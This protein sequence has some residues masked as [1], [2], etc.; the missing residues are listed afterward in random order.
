M[1]H[2]RLQFGDAV[3]PVAIF[4]GKIQVSNGK[5]CHSC[6]SGSAPCDPPSCLHIAIYD[7]GMVLAVEGDLLLVPGDS[8]GNLVWAINDTAEYPW[9]LHFIT[10]NREL[11]TYGNWQIHVDYWL[12]GASHIQY[13]VGAGEGSYCDSLAGNF[14]GFYTQTIVISPCAEL[15]ALATP[16]QSPRK[17]GCNSCRGLA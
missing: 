2:D 10:W 4:N 8:R 3:S 1:G 5:I 9:Q 15:L 12:S 17:S 13:G 6:C 14:E 7:E 11:G 16:L